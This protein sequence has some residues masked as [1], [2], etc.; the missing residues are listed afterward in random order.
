M[1]SP[2]PGCGHL[3]GCLLSGRMY[4]LQ[5]VAVAAITREP[6]GEAPC[7][8][9]LQVYRRY[10]EEYG[11]ATRPHVTFTYFQPK[12]RAWVWAATRGACSVSCGA[13]EA[14]GRAGPSLACPLHGGGL[15][16]LFLPRVAMGDLQLPGPG[17][18]PVGGGCP[19]RR[20]PTAGGLARALHPWG[21]PPIVSAVCGALPWVMGPTPPGRGRVP[22]CVPSRSPGGSL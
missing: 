17:Q 4:G 20:E 21:L 11:N 13:G 14:R 16:S 19:V 3:S 8:R 5:E 15:A 9:L 7:A 12:L 6:L 1:L 22:L 18:E 10:G 2:E